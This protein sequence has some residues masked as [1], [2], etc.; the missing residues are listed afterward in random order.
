[1]S[2]IADMFAQLAGLRI[3]GGCDDCDAYQEVRECGGVHTIVVRHDDTCPWY[4][5]WRVGRTR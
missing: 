5:G 1:M 4:A 2:D 3:P